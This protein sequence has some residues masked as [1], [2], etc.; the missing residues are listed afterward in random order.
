MDLDETALFLREGATVALDNHYILV[1]PAA[2]NYSRIVINENYTDY[3]SY[4]KNRT[5][6]EFNIERYYKDEQ[7]PID[8]VVA[9]VEIIGARKYT[10]EQ[11]YEPRYKD[12]TLILRVPV[13][14]TLVIP[15]LVV[16]STS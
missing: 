4:T 16:G 9:T 11:K 12:N 3:V 2:K 1:Y 5:H 15:D 7:V 8:N 13:N 6:F 10:V 14:S